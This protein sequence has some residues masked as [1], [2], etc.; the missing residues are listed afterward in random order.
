[1]GCPDR[2]IVYN[3]NAALDVLC[4][5]TTLQFL[6][7][8]QATEGQYS[9]KWQLDG[10]IVNEQFP[11]ASHQ[12]AIDRVGKCPRDR[13][14]HLAAAKSAPSPRLGGTSWGNKIIPVDAAVD[15]NTVWIQGTGLTPFAL[16]FLGYGSCSSPRTD[17][18]WEEQSTNP[19]IQWKL[20]TV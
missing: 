16:K 11:I 18:R 15:C 10:I 5:D 9:K 6:A 13:Y 20:T 8:G 19:L 17:F 7:D 4:T 2:F 14:I 12:V 3:N 1:V